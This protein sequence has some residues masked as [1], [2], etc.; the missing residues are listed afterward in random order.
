MLLERSG[1][2]TGR[3]ENRG[4]TCSPKPALGPL[5]SSSLARSCPP[6]EAPIKS[7]LR[8]R[9]FLQFG[10]GGKEHRPRADLSHPLFRVCAPGRRLQTQLTFTFEEADFRWGASGQTVGPANPG[11]LRLSHAGLGASGTRSPGKATGG[12]ARVV[13]PTWDVGSTMGAGLSLPDLRALSSPVCGSY[14]SNLYSNLCL[15]RSNANEPWEAMFGRL[16]MFG[17]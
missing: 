17:R 6:Q 8:G 3:G 2:P 11:S 15:P 7:R 4:R 9:I 5:L 16:E 12:A 14:F 10:G 1:V 13:A